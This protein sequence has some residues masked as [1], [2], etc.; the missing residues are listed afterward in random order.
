MVSLTLS[1][2]LLAAL[3]LVSAVTPSS[4]LFTDGTIIAFDQEA[5]DLN[6]I[7]N[8]SVLVQQDRI[9]GIW[10]SGE[11]PSVSIPPNTTVVDAAGKIIAPGFVDTHRHGWQTLF[12]TMFSNITL[13]EYF[14]HFGEAASAGRVDAEQVYIGQLAGL[15]ESLN[16]GTTTSLDHA[17]HTWSDET[18]WAGLNAS[19]DSGAR[20]FWSYAFHEVANYTIAQQLVNFRDI[21]NASPQADTAVELGIAFD[22]FDNGSVD[23]ETITSVIDLAKEANI[24]VLTTHSG[25]GVYGNDNSPTTLQSLN[26][27]NTSI[28]VVFS[29]GSYVTLKDT[30]LLRSTNQFLSITPESEM[31]FGLGR[32]T[33]SMAMDQAA[34]GVDTHAFSS[35]DLVTQA[36]MFLQTTR[37]AVTDELFRKWQAP[38]SNP[39]S[40]TQAFLLATRNGGLALHRPDLGVLSVGAKADIVV[41]DGTSPS[42]LGWVDPVA[43]IIMHSN[44]GDVEHVLVDG[45]F[46]KRDRKLV[47]GDYSSVKARFLEASNRIQE[48]WKQIPRPQL[49]DLT[50]AGA[51]IVDLEQVDVTPGDGNGY[52]QLHV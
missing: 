39:M 41:W 15:Y 1:L 25:G 18:S 23:Q 31:G 38:G 5:N 14:L 11:A 19:I 50:Q 37:S 4:I 13:I 3:D 16:A 7:R 32:P 51:R 2:G 43:A 30:L 35:S 29:H 48:D 46:V 27:L 36:R 44:V 49:G 8:G 17:H 42:L 10:S 12:K 21:V 22:S 6:V 9:T 52:G 34:L 47:V 45:K 20:V 33:S 26:I 24:S 40:V 28:P